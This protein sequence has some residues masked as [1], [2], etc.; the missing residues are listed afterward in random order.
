MIKVRKRKHTLVLRRYSQANAKPMAAGFFHNFSFVFEYL[1][2]NF[3]CTFCNKCKNFKNKQYL[4]FINNFKS[5][6]KYVLN[7][8][9]NNSFVRGLMKY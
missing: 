1:S 5:S 8:L 3:P 7:T 2:T 4:F 9:K 6:S